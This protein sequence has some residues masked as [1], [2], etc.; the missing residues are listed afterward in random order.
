MTQVRKTK[1]GKNQAAKLVAFAV[2]SYGLNAARFGSMKEA[3][4]H[5]KRLVDVSLTQLKAQG[6][7][8]SPYGRSIEIRLEAVYEDLPTREEAWAA[9]EA[10]MVRRA[11]GEI[12]A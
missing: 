5:A 8:S 6:A 4:D 2:H 10:E 11:T 3:A 1:T 12:H 9:E 7:G